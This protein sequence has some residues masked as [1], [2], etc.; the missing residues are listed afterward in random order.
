MVTQLTTIIERKKFLESF[1][2]AGW[3]LSRATVTNAEIGGPTIYITD[4]ETGQLLLVALTMNA[5]PLLT[6]RAREDSV[7]FGDMCNMLG[8]LLGDLVTNKIPLDEESRGALT[9]AA[10]L[11]IAGTQGYAMMNNTGVHNGQYLVI[12]HPDASFP[13]GHIL[14]PVPIRAVKPLSPEDIEAAVEHVLA[15]DRRNH[16]ERF[17]RAKVLAFRIRNAECV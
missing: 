16:P 17:P 15:I 4:I 11:Y 10:G 14:R 8:T 2:A 6:E 9:A 1:S 3:N 12:R 13:G 5:I 7:S